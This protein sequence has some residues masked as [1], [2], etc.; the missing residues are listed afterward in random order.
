VQEYILDAEITVNSQ[1]AVDPD[2]EEEGNVS[3]TTMED[4]VTDGIN[5]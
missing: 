5:T 2:T 3:V 1:I 4:E